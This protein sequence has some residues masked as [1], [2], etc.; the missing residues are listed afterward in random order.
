MVFISFRIF[1]RNSLYKILHDIWINKSDLSSKWTRPWSLSTFK[2]RVDFRQAQALP[3]TI[4]YLYTKLTCMTTIVPASDPTT[5]LV[6]SR[7]V[8]RH[9]GRDKTPSVHTALCATASH[10]MTL[11]MSFSR[12]QLTKCSSGFMRAWKWFVVWTLPMKEFFWGFDLCYNF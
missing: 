3:L 10:Q 2:Q 12:L 5:I 9:V 8:S 11:R 7:E 4:R 6:P 1:I